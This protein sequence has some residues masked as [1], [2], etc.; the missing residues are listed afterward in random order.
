MGSLFMYR[1]FNLILGLS[2]TLS[3]ITKTNATESIQ[4]SS[5]VSGN[6]ESNISKNL[7][8]YSLLEKRIIRKIF[9]R[10]NMQPGNSSFGNRRFGLDG[11]EVPFMTKKRDFTEIDFVYKILSKVGVERFRT[12]ESYWHRLSKN[13][14][15]YSELDFQAKYAKRY[16]MVL[17][18]NVGYPPRDLN[19]AP[20]E[21]STFKAEHEHLFRKYISSLLYRYKGVVA[22]IEV[23]NEVDFPSIWWVG[24]GPEEYVRDCRI[25]KEEVLKVDPRI[26]IVAFG[27]T[28]SRTKT[29]GGPSG[30]RKFIDQSIILGINKYVDLYSLHYT[31]QTKE[32]QFV[33]YFKNITNNFSPKKELINTEDSDSERPPEIIKMFARNL[34]FHKF[35]SVD[36]FLAKDYIENGKLIKSGLFNSQWHP[37]MSLLAYALS[38]DSMKNRQLLGLSEPSPGV[39]AYILSA[40][41]KMQQPKYSIIM[42]KN[43]NASSASLS[44]PPD[45]L[46]FK[47]QTVLVSGITSIISAYNWK[48]DILKYYKST[49]SFELD[50]DPIVIFTDTLPKWK[51]LSLQKWRKTHS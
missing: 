31:W 49:K 34:F 41:T 19:I 14:N 37:K 28:G 5:S 48:L 6:I 8:N 36:Y 40:T 39:E 4:T 25:V 30:G 15:N 26:K 51:I 22:E 21:V 46:K 24:A 2:M 38:V 42:W 12:G 1:I 33:D 3:V 44:S 9:S 35:K 18:L 23:G 11:M 27:A 29:G 10:K 7:K 43:N 13:F 45:Q 47:D 16:G 17:R 20:S 50:Q 32:N